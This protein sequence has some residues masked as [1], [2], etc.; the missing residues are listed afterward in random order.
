MTMN[1]LHRGINYSLAPYGF[2]S[3]DEAWDWIVKVYASDRS[4]L[5]VSKVEHVF[6]SMYFV[7]NVMHSG[8]YVMCGTYWR[9]LRGNDA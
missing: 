5:M 7:L 2:D 3:H 8:V 9:L 1:M 4:Q 6:G